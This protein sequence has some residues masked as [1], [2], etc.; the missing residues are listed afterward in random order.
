MLLIESNQDGTFGSYV[1][2][3]PTSDYTDLHNTRFYML[4]RSWIIFIVLRL[5]KMNPFVYC[6]KH[7]L[8]LARLA[9]LLNS[10]TVDKT[11]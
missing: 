7:A 6:S 4:S 11:I 2:T 9:A 1:V 5:D 10:Q 8:A 3:T